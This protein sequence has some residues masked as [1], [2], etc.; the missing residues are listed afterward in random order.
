MWQAIKRLRH[1]ERGAAIITVA[2]FVPV[3]LV[4]ASFVIDIADGMER[5]RQLQLQ[6]D[7]GALAAGQEFRKCRTDTDA[8]KTNANNDIKAV[9]QDY[10]ITRNEYFPGA[11]A[12][13]TLTF[14]VNDKPCQDGFVKVALTETGSPDFFSKDTDEYSAD[15][16]VEMRELQV[17][18]GLLPLG[19]PIPDPEDA[20]VVFVDESN[21]GAEIARGELKPGASSQGLEIWETKSP[22]EDVNIASEHVGVRICTSDSGSQCYDQESTDGLVHIRGWTDGTGGQNSNGLTKAP[23]LESVA[24]ESGSPAC[25]DARFNPSFSPTVPECGAE[26]RNVNVRAVLDFGGDPRNALGSVKAVVGGTEYPLTISTSAPWHATGPVPIPSAEGPLDID[27]KWEAQKGQLGTGNSAKCSDKKGNPCKGEFLGVQRHLRTYL[28]SGP[29]QLME[30][31]EPGGAAYANSLQQG[32]HDLNVKIGIAGTLEAPGPHTLRAS[33]GSGSQ[34]F[35]LDCNAAGG[36][37]VYSQILNGCDPFYTVNRDNVECGSDFDFDELSAPWPC[38]KVETGDRL[39]QVPGALNLRILGKEKPK[40]TDCPKNGDPGYNYWPAYPDPDPRLIYI[41]QTA[42]DAFGS[43]GNVHSVSIT[44]LRAFY[45]IAWQGNTGFR[46]P[47]NDDDYDDL[48]PGH[49][50]G[51]YEPRLDFP[52]TGGSG[53]K[54]NLVTG[55]TPCT[56]VLVE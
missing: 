29:I 28:G 16:V 44:G 52:N 22:V 7:A 54:C 19:V 36:N 38:V 39:S 6:A 48:P 42:I 53:T 20:E 46:N 24:L 10:A 13:G 5:R 12:K 50:V 21:G 8:N 51:Y 32:S 33:G 56:P 15:A 37:Q 55:F 34:T 49:V 25:S 26:N 23:V 1:E 41:F 40:A 35:L 31:S 30:V 9:A 2:A 43:G 3:F 18:N 14:E 47:C 4:I 11:D 45:V 17:L 27:I